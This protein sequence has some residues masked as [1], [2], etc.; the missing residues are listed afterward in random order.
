MGDT[1]KTCLLPY[2]ELEAGFEAVY[3][4]EKPED[5]AGAAIFEDDSGKLIRKWS[6]WNCRDNPEQWDDE[7]RYLNRLQEEIGE[8]TVDIRR[9][10]AHIASLTPCDTGLPVTVDE[11]LDAIGRGKLE[12]P[13]FHNGCWNSDM[14]GEAKNTQPRHVEGMQIAYDVLTGYLAG[15]SEERFI[16]KYPY[17]E[18]FVRRIYQWLGPVTDLT[19]LQKLLI[20][21]MLLP[22]DFFTRAS[23]ANPRS[24][25]PDG[26]EAACREAMR[27]CY[28]DGGRGAAIDGEIATLAGLP[29]ISMKYP[30]QAYKAQIDDPKKK[31]LYVLCCALAHGLHTL[32]DCH[33]SAFRW[34]ENWIYSIGTGKWGIPTRKIGTER[35]R[36]S[37]LLFGYLLG[38][39]KWL[40]EIPMQFLLLDLGHVDF[41]FDPKNEIVRVYAYLGEKKTPVKE[42]LSA[43]LWH[44][45]MYS[46][47]GLA[48]RD[49]HT[50]LIAQAHRAGISV[51]EW[52]DSQLKESGTSR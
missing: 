22:F 47:G 32:G 20:E 42:W 40:L 19:Q 5:A 21:R 41:G 12:E 8:L 4:N 10:R 3:I 33:H 14:W 51:R 34:I 37:R 26:A 45:L 27:N 9:I 46:T 28:Q 48:W 7:I 36:V 31:D 38:L 35:R 11:L 15:D 44:S 17:A 52:M 39:D 49:K 18:G 13:S 29:E 30:E 6:L 23:H 16:E 24:T 25:W 1:T 50:D 2:D 43:C